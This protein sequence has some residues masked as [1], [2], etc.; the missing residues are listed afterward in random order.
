MDWRWDFQTGLKHS[1]LTLKSDVLRPSDKSAQVPLGLDIL[2]DT[3]VPNT[4]NQIHNISEMEQES[5]TTT[6]KKFLM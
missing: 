3:K 1:F 4:L 5:V 6:P 2:T